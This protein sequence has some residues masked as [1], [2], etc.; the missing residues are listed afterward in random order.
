MP[1]TA[2]V[3]GASRGIGAEAARLLA[4]EGYAVVVNYRTS[5][6]LAQQVEQSIRDEGGEATTFAADVAVAAQADEL[7]RFALGRYG[8]LDVV[9]NNAGVALRG[10]V[11][12]CTDDDYDRVFNTNM[13]GVFHMC[14][15]A[16]PHM[17]RAGRGS[18]VN[19]SSMWGVSGASCEAVYAASKAA[20]IGFTKSL[21]LELAPSGVAVNCLAPGVVDTDMNASLTDDERE[22][23]C[24]DI[25]MGRFL[26][27]EETAREILHLISS[28]GLTGQTLLFTGGLVM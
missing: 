19:V 27:A 14:R 20:V 24:A 22:A 11:S 9:V 25:P 12:D 23:L 15:A 26:T 10:L 3:T 5:S 18:I 21:A 2:I 8:R 7:V 28:P 4:R 16:Y 17:V 13:R 1:K 6:A